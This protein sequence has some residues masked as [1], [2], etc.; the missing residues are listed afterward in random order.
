M[1]QPLLPKKMPQT[2]QVNAGG[3]KCQTGPPDF[4]NGLKNLG[5][6]SRLFK[7]T[8]ATY[9]GAMKGRPSWL[10][11]VYGGEILPSSVG[12]ILNHC[13]YYKDLY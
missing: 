6:A 11:R 12:I 13:K 10:F 5:L 1:S 8:Q 3:S 7:L 4:P 9:I 2:F